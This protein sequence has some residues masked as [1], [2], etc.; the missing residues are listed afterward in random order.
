MTKGQSICSLIR[1]RVEQECATGDLAS[2]F[3]TRVP[4]KRGSAAVAPAPTTA[5]E[6]AAPY[7]EKTAAAKAAPARTAPSTAKAAHSKPAAAHTAP[8]ARPVFTPPKGT[9]QAQLDALRAHIGECPFCPILVRNRKKI[10]FGSGNVDAT[11]MF[12]GEAPGQD[13]DEQG[14]PFVGRAGQLLTNIIEKGM[15][16]Q[17]TEV[18]IANILKCRPPNNRQPQPDEIENCAPFLHAQ[19]DIIKP[20]V[21]VALGAYASHYITGENT[22]ISKLRGEWR[23]YR[24]IPV[25]PTFHPSYLLRSYSPDNRR[26]VWED[27]KKVMARVE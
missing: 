12:V 11:I 17:R 15:G 20:Q 1:A 7:A 4:R 5:R 3:I 27:V 25:M 14:L 8:Q 26:L 19:L 10:V 22:P 13:E 6:P 18:Y 2:M 24:G 16:I 21:I 23:A 9:K